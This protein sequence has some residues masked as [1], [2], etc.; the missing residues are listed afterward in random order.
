MAD[1]QALCIPQTESLQMNSQVSGAP[2]IFPVEGTSNV[3]MTQLQ[4][5]PVCLSGVPSAHAV[6]PVTLLTFTTKTGDF[7]ATGSDAQAAASLS[8]NLTAGALRWLA[9]PTF[10]RCVSKGVRRRP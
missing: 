2:R 8:A 5:T 6:E 10:A 7:A 3:T 4:L 1:F 9:A